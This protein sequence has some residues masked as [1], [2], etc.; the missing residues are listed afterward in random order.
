MLGLCGINHELIPGL[1]TNDVVIP[2]LDTAGPTSVCVKVRLT[3]QDE[4]VD[5]ARSVSLRTHY[6][7]NKNSIEGPWSSWCSVLGHE[8]PV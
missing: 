5:V 7:A 1:G 8:T 2:T 6:H 4:V 3:I